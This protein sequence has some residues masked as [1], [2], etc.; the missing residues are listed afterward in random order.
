MCVGRSQGSSSTVWC[1]GCRRDFSCGSRWWGG[2]VR[3]EE[4]SS[5]KRE[6]S[7]ACVVGGPC[8][9]RGNRRGFGRGE[10]GWSCGLLFH[11]SRMEGRMSAPLFKIFQRWLLSPSLL[12]GVAPKHQPK[13]HIFP[14]PLPLPP[15]SSY[16]TSSFFHS[17]KNSNGPEPFATTTAPTTKLL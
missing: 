7:P 13:N 11:M 16:I 6:E 14:T 8:A 3:E 10:D 4:R 9:S 1:S 5:G 15:T 2:V 12:V 17:K